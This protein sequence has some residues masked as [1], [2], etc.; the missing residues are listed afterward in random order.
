MTEWTIKFWTPGNIPVDDGQTFG[1]ASHG[2]SSSN[3]WINAD[4]AATECWKTRMNGEVLSGTYSNVLNLIKKL[5]WKPVAAIVLFAHAVGINS[6]L[7]NWL[8]LLPDVPV[9]G[10][11]AALGSGQASGE[12]LPA[13]AD[14]VV[15]LINDG[16]CHVDTLN[17]HDR[18]GQTAE[19]RADGP[20]IITHLREH[21]DWIPA[22]V[23][24]RTLQAGHNRVTDDCES[25]T[26]TD[27]NERNI[28]ISFDNDQLHTGA[29]LPVDGHLELRT[30]SRADAAARLANFCSEPNALV[31]G[32]AGLRS[33]LDEPL[34][35]APGTLVGFM[36]GELVTLDGRPQFGNLMA[37][38]LVRE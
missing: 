37:S 3:I 9:A 4:E 15:L 31:F 23:A 2:L 17:V 20:R 5:S 11:G 6:F 10:G 30:V 16:Q 18:T 7:E 36:F 8:E 19:L 28:H 27:V 12:L 24:F 21:D 32:C 33:L 26:F 13:A 29:D 38:R 22:S 34:S 35:V 14:V 25:I 1:C